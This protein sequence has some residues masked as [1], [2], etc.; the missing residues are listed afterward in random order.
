M[1]THKNDKNK[2]STHHQAGHP[3]PTQPGTD[4][5]PHPDAPTPDLLP[6]CQFQ[7]EERNA[8]DDE[9]DEVGNQIGT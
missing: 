6:H 5:V 1:K 3:D 8:D 4:I 2:T 7:E 9:E